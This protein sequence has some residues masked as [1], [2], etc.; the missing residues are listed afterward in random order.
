M[1][2]SGRANPLTVVVDSTWLRVKVQLALYRFEQRGVRKIHWKTTAMGTVYALSWTIVP[3]N[4]F[5]SLQDSLLFQSNYAGDFDDY[6]AVFVQ[7]HGS[8]LFA[9]FKAVPGFGK[10]VRAGMGERFI[11]EHN[12]PTLLYWAA[13]DDLSPRDLGQL[14]INAADALDPRWITMILPLHPGKATHAITAARLKESSEDTPFDLPGVHFAR[15]AA[16]PR[17][18]GTFLIVSMVVDRDGRSDEDVISQL[19]ARD[20]PFWT[21]VAHAVDA[22]DNEPTRVLLEHLVHQNNSLS[23]FCAP[24]ATRASICAQ[25]DAGLLRLRS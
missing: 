4:T 9:H 8:G 14:G 23:Y 7:L 1:N 6:I 22:K 12:Y 3:R 17:R 19:V 20:R 16:V 11:Q 10:I 24:G 5:G 2:R 21:E 13:Y 15:I 18:T 25:R